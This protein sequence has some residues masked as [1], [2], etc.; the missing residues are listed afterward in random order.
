M[1]SFDF[2]V[3]TSFFEIGRLV[4]RN[5]KCMKASA[6]EALLMS[7]FHFQFLRDFIPQLNLDFIPY[8]L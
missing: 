5:L 3:G 6:F 4:F 1:S 8:F 2:V 7:Q